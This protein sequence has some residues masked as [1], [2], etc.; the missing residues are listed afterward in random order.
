VGGGDRSRLGGE[1]DDLI[2]ASGSDRTR[3]PGAGSVFLNSGES[4]LDE[5]T[6][7][8]PDGLPH[9]SHGLG[10]LLIGLTRGSH[11]DNLCAL[12]QPCGKGAATRETLQIVP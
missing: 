6:P 3:P 9:D 5:S 10:N 12:H 11:Q 1:A 8:E 7:P 2:N 4:V